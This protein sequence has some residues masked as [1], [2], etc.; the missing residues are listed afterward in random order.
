[1]GIEP[2][3]RLISEN[4]K[5][6]KS[7]IGRFF[8]LTNTIKNGIINFKRRWFF[9]QRQDNTTVY[10]LIR[11]GVGESNILRIKSSVPISEQNGGLVRISFPDG[12]GNLPKEIGSL[13]EVIVKSVVNII[14]RI[15]IIKFRPKQVILGL[16][17]SNTWTEAEENSVRQLV[18]ILLKARGLETQWSTQRKIGQTPRRL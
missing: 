17:V 12:I 15:K 10:L 9:V 1:V 2:Q 16:E 7:P 3:V 6:Q 11:E 18:D 13:A 14:P 4:G 8:G 5:L